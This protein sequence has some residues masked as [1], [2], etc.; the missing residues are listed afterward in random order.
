MAVKDGRLRATALE[1]RLGRG[2]FAGLETLKNKVQRPPENLK[3]VPPARRKHPPRRFNSMAVKDG[4][5]RAAAR[6]EGI[7]SPSEQVKEE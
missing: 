7:R 4:R 5:L 1:R 2:P 6:S 3:N